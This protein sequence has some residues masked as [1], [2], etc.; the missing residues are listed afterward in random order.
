[1]VWSITLTCLSLIALEHLELVEC[2]IEIRAEW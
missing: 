1:M 2:S